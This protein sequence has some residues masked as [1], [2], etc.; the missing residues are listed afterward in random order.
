MA[1]DKRRFSRIF[2]DMPAELTVADTSYTIEQIANLSIGGCLLK[3]E[4]DI[5]VG[6]ECKFAIILNDTPQDLKVEVNG[7]IVRSDAETVG[8]KFTRINPDDLVHLQNI[9]RYNAEDPDKISDE[10][11]RHPGLV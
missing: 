6:A 3:I 11:K 4:D 7:E 5:P 2:Y 8:I 9:I 10:I 1:E